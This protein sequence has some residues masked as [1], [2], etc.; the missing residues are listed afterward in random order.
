MTIQ[1]V[2]IANRGEIAR[3]LIRYFKE[4]GS[5]TVSVFSEPDVEQPW[6]EEADYPTY[7][8]GY[9]VAETYLNPM[10]V[11]S[12]A[13]DGGCDAIHP[14]YC[15]L[16][17]RADFVQMCMNANVAVIG[18]DPNTL[19]KAVDRFE[20]RKVARELNIPMIPASE[21]LGETE[22]GMAAGAQ[23]GVPLF[24]KTPAGG[25]VR[26]CDNLAD[27]PK[28][29]AEV[30]AA[31]KIVTGESA[32][33]L[34]RAVDV[35]R[36]VGTTVVRDRDGSCVHLGDTDTSLQHDFHTWIEEIGD[37]VV[38]PL[39]EKIG[40]ASV[41]LAH[42]IGWLG[43]GRVRWAITPDKGWYLLGFTARLTTGYNLVEQ[44]VGLDLV[45]TQ[46][47][48]QEGEPLGFGQAD[49]VAG[50]H[51][52]QLRVLPF[53]EA[54]PEALIEGTIERMVLPEGENVLAETGTAEGQPVSPHTDPLLVKLTVT[55]PTRHAA[56]VRA[57]AA[58]EALVIEG[59]PTN[60]EFLLRALAD[61]RVWRGDYAIDTLDRILSGAVDEAAPK[62]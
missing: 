19:W 26:R 13:L 46:V 10:K 36:A 43:V 60:R 16:A 49:V 24:V 28:V 56:L 39:H 59:V 7:L 41:E 58:L 12:A 42:A 23:L 29:V 2:L 55:G 31:A 20:L 40:A 61:E 47:R 3:R 53:D 38:G 25:V 15:F 62:A 30:R 37:S 32:V 14:G 18:N 8:N 50:R 17:E 35:Y 6:V 48:L 54:N 5:E 22:D 51:G 11:V 27:L 34:E 45:Q 1:R 21:P 44:V 57:R 52:V 33:Y 9:T 4:A